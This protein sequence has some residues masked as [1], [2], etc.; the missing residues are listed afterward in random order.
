MNVLP[1]INFL[2]SM[3]PLAPA[4]GYWKKLHSIIGVYLWNWKK[5]KIKTST[6]YRLKPSGGINLPN[7]EWYSWG[8]ALRSLSICLKPDI[9]TSWKPIE[10]Q[11]L[12][13]QD[14]SCFL[15]SNIPLKIVKNKCGPIISHLISV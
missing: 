4:K 11:L 15:Y 8:F 5:A 3:L 14:M 2:N 7:F 12:Q 13:P 9:L 6:L 10:E 1:R